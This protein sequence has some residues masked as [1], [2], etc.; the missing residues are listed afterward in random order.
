VRFKNTLAP[1]KGAKPRVVRLAICIP[2]SE[3]WK[4]AFGLSLCRMLLY[5]PQ[6]ESGV[7]IEMFQIFHKSGSMLA[8]MRQELVEGVLASEHNFTHLLFVDADQTF[9]PDT[10][11][12]LLRWHKP[13]VACNVAI[14]RVPSAPTARVKAVGDKGDPLFTRGDSAGL[15]RVWRVGTGVMMVETKVF[16]QL[17]KPWFLDTWK[18]EANRFQG[19]DWYFCEKCEG[20]YIPLFVDQGLSWEVGHVGSY[21]YEHIMIEQQ[22]EIERIRDGS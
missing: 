11:Y 20:K 10:L 8:R 21:S 12:R 6:V 17:E 15:E 9:P 2:C 22:L 14:K 4:S 16:R 3:I 13:V 19:E 1:R 5:R 18:A 7:R